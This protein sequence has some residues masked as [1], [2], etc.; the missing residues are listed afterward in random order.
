MN[1]PRYT[2]IKVLLDNES[3]RTTLDQSL[4]KFSSRLDALSPRDRSLANLIIFGTLRWQGQLDWI[5]H[6]FSTRRLNQIRPVVLYI[7]RAALYQI[8]H[9]D[10]IPVSAAV[11]TAVT[12]AGKMAGKPA[13]GFVNA[14]LRNAGKNYSNV[15]LPDREKDPALFLAASKSLPLWLSKN[16]IST[17]GFE[18]ALKICDAVNEIPVI[19]IRANTL[20]TDR[21]TLASQ[22]DP[23]VENLSFTEYSK[24]GISFTRPVL[25][26]SDMETFKQGFFQ[27][28]DEGAQLIIPLLDPRPGET[29]LDACAGLGGKTGHAGQAMENKGCI[30]AWD[31][32]KNK[33]LALASE[34]L[35]IGVSI[36][37]PEQ[38]D[39]LQSDDP[40]YQNYFDRVL[41]DAPC[42]GLGVLRR[43]PDAKWK[44]TQ[45]DITRLSRMQ[46]SMMFKAADLVRPGGR[47]VYAVCSCQPRENE[48]VIFSFLDKRKDFFLINAEQK[49]L[50]TYPDTLSMDGF[51]AASLEKK[52]EF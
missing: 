30:H 18:N 25:P 33:L 31:I 38:K 16:W 19:T 27:V 29:I 41:L 45:K 9:M 49:F 40:R 11:N 35:R 21:Q 28:Q 52:H 8:I 20:K 44:R 2:A 4:A 14:V 1:D 48:D 15:P 17:F 46:K 32:E 12:M 3:S 51:F 6:S 39:M 10:R 36:V 42:S 47:L 13:A 24:Q 5:I 7:I 23:F 34:M 22:L 50:K 26:I 43:N 37:T